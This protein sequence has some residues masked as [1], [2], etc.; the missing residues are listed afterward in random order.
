MTIAL[1]YLCSR[2]VVVAA[3]TKVTIGTQLFEGTKLTS[4]W[5]KSGNFGIANSSDD[6]NAAAALQAEI[7]QDLE[8]ASLSDYRALSNLF[9][10]RMT[11]WS[12][13]FGQRTPPATQFIFGAKLMGD[14]PKLFFCEPP[15]TVKEIDDYVATGSGATVTDPLYATFFDNNGGS[16]AD[17]QVVLKRIAYLIYRAKKDDLYSGKN[18][19]CV[20]ICDEQRGIIEVEREDFKTAEVYAADVDFVASGAAIFATGSDDAHIEQDALDLADMLKQGNLRNV[21]FHGR[22]GQRITL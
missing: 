3:D 19:D 15:N 2:G 5:G 13:A 18:T 10:Q 21:E 1:G 8:R 16:H 12:D 17:V 6:G 11:E 20:V 9:K 7:G 14:G 4:V 22:D